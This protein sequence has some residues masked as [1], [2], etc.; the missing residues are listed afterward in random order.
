M[1]RRSRKW[2]GVVAV[3]IAL[4]V[5]A[6]YLSHRRF[7]RSISAQLSGDPSLLAQSS[8]LSP[9]LVRD[10]GQVS[11][12]PA[13][14]NIAATR[15]PADVALRILALGDSFTYGVEV[16]PAASYPQILSAR[17]TE[18]TGKHLEVLNFG[19]GWYGAAQTYRLWD[20]QARGT[21][22]DLVLLGPE[23]CFLERELTFN[24]AEDQL[25]DYLHG[26]YILDGDGLRF[27]DVLGTSREERFDAYYSFLPTWQYLRYDTK[28]PT[29]MRGF[30]PANKTIAN[31]FY[32]S[33]LSGEAEQ[34]EL[35]RRYTRGILQSGAP[36][37]FLQRDE[38]CLKA[39]GRAANL[40]TAEFQAP[41]AAIYR[42]PGGHLSGAGNALL[43]ETYLQV[44]SGGTLGE[45]ERIEL[46]DGRADR[47]IDWSAVTGIE[48]YLDQ[49]RAAVLI[50]SPDTFAV[51]QRFPANPAAE[52]VRSYLAIEAKHSAFDQLWIPLQTELTS[53]M[54]VR[55]ER[56][57]AS[58]VVGHVE[59][60]D[61]GGLGVVRTP[62]FDS[63][64]VTRVQTL[65]P[66]QFPLQS[67]DLG[68]AR[69]LL[70]GKPIL[71][72][73]RNL[74]GLH[75]FVPVDRYF[76]FFRPEEADLLDVRRL[77]ASGE[78]TLLLHRPQGDERVVVGTWAKVPF[79]VRAEVDAPTRARLLG[80]LKRP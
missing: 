33:R 29:A 26:R 71:K 54:E 22:P 5:G 49:Q 32:Y 21:N 63:R 60:L 80:L 68:V 61:G 69:V 17:L 72:V 2:L 45:P 36:L 31:P 77:P 12:D 1:S 58:E 14:R 65:W 28:P 10:L 73:A 78:V 38:A 8:G 40:A 11:D 20:Q 37:V 43:A 41:E 79:P 30:L 55:L 24:H 25:R 51:G 64:V 13:R 74:Y 62:S 18:L 6:L 67:A 9:A 46:S 75:S 66:T 34:A 4:L 35:L 39:V 7:L 19:N 57:G 70:A 16:T 44:I 59:L 53:G 23:T 15:R 42:Q 50:K 52:G 56:G 76:D 48:L 47:R 3:N 27:I